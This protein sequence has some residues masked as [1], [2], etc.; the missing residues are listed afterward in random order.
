MVDIIERFSEYETP[1]SHIKSP[2]FER[3]GVKHLFTRRRGGVS[4]GVYESLNFACGTVSPDSAENVLENHRRAAA[5]LGMRAE[6]ICKSYQTHSSAVLTVGQAERGTG[7]TKPPFDTDADGLVT[8]E[9]GVV[10]SVRG[11]DCVTVLLCDVR[12]GICGA[13]HSGWRGTAGR[14]AARTV[15]AMKALGADPKDIIAA[16]GPSARS[17]CYNVNE[18][19]ERAFL[20]ADSNFAGC[21]TR[22]EGKLFLDLQKAVSLTLMKSGLSDANISD[23]GECTVCDSINYFSHRRSGAARGTL[24]AFIVL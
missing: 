8:A 4:E 7:V 24:S 13:C 11:A 21:F 9:E 18:E 17:C 3:H 14:I 15:E 20:A 19:L 22:R 1:I 2:L 5:A 23:C 12:R 10:L 6:D 16:I